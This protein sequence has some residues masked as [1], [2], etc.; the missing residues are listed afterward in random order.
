MVGAVL[1][2]SFERNKSGAGLSSSRL[3]ST[4]RMEIN[5]RAYTVC[6]RVYCYG[7]SGSAMLRGAGAE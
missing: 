6:I 2:E 4:T 1:H 3:P 7:T 5:K